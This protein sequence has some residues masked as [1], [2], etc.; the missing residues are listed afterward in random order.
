[1]ST[2]L[3][4]FLNTDLHKCHFLEGIKIYTHRLTAIFN[5]GDYAKRHA[6]H[7]GMNL[8]CFHHDHGTVVM[9]SKPDTQWRTEERSSSFHVQRTPVFYMFGSLDE[10][11]TS[12]QSL[13]E[14]L[15]KIQVL[16]YNQTFFEGR[17]GHKTQCKTQIG[18]PR[19]SFR[20]SEEK[21]QFWSKTVSKFQVE[22]QIL[23]QR[24]N[25][26]QINVPTKFTTKGFQG[27]LKRCMQLWWLLSYLWAQ[28]STH[29]NGV[30]CWQI[31]HFAQ[32]RA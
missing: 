8:P 6:R 26:M 10:L 20:T 18:W 29:N 3:R 27:T 2:F 15:V 4:H 14:V 21:N 13:V 25:Q 9:L 24:Y 22:L 16:G 19:F 23:L 12:W 1:M 5:P 28:V 32:N 31:M 17:R 11:F 30:A 7:H